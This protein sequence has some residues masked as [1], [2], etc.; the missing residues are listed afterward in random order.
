MNEKLR[1]VLLVEHSAPQREELAGRLRK[2][3]GCV[4]HAVGSPVEAAEILAGGEVC[5]LIVGLDLPLYQG[6]ALHQF[7]LKHHS[8]VLVLPVVL[9]G[10][11]REIAEV[12]RTGAFSY[13]NAPYN[14]TEAVIVT[15]RAL[16]F[17]DLL[18]HKEK[19]GAKV[20]KS[21]GFYGIIGNSTQ[22]QEIYDLIDKLAEDSSTVLIQGESGT[23]K[24]LVARALHARSHRSLKNFV[25]INCAAIPEDLLES[26]LFGY[27]KG[28]FTGALL[29]KIGH[30][31]HAD[32]GTLFLD[33][34]GDMQPNLQ[35]KL[36]R[37]IQ[38]RTFVPVGGL[39]P[40][41]VDVRI[42]AATHRDLEA[43]IAVGRFRED[44]YYRL[45]VIPLTLPPLR[46]RQGDIPLLLHKFVQI[47]NR[48]R[49]AR[50]QGF[51]PEALASLLAYPWPGNV[52]EL[53]N[54][55]QRL[56]VLYGGR[57]IGVDEL[58]DKYAPPRPALLAPASPIISDEIHFGP[59][60]IDFDAVIHD[61]EDKLILRALQLTAGN[62]KEAA[63]LLHLNRTT[64]LEKIKKK[65]LDLK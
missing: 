18:I 19:R 16:Y 42:I 24:E 15:A 55:M 8:Q 2:E 14:F 30:I 59:D 28:A 47:F 52:R 31:Q 63:R 5:V 39:E 56:V 35:A 10:D 50:L 4:V 37:V 13:I 33:E 40:V 21:D 11:Q 49:T 7:V 25:P 32:G 20:R 6:L 9:L 54:L 34:I 23:G 41:P 65:G 64:L 57:T 12:L 36:L 27:R 44:L 3:L 17:Y 22:M 43:E 58:P 61:L 53:E 62:K 26:E 51:T 48:N 60:G 38:D 45:S 46:E 29:T 1:N